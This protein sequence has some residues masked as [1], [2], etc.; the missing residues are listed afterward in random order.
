MYERCLNEA[1]RMLAISKEVVL[2]VKEVWRQLAAEGKR[3]SFDVPALTDFDALLE[4]DKRFEII[5]SQT[6]PEPIESLFSEDSEED[7]SNLG[8]LG[9]YS[10]DRVKL[11]RVRMPDRGSRDPA[12]EKVGEDDED[13]VP[14]NVR[15]LSA[16][17]PS[18]PLESKKRPSKEVPLQRAS[19]GKAPRKTSVKSTPP[20]ASRA[21]NAVRKPPKKSRK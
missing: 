8:S 15:G 7:E 21:R 16:T 18:R 17:K 6:D 20:V 5:S 9:F 10:E 12:L 1:E 11:R 4:G 2:P 13:I 3:R 19:R 14:F